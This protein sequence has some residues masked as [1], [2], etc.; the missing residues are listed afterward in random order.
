[1]EMVLDVAL[2]QDK[3]DLRDM[4]AVRARRHRQAAREGSAAWCASVL[5]WARTSENTFKNPLSVSEHLWCSC[6]LCPADSCSGQTTIT[7]GHFAQS[8]VWPDWPR[9]KRYA[10]GL[11]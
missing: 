9:R 10:E 4:L 7:I 5:R 6:V 2:K 11:Q 3:R 1:M 8:D